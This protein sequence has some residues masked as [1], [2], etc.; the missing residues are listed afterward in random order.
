MSA[1]KILFI[2]AIDYRVEVEQRYPSLGLA[3]LVSFLRKRFDSKR[4]VFKVI[5]RGVENVLESY[6]PDIVGISSVSQ[7]F[8]LAGRYAEMAKKKDA[9]V[10]VGGVHISVLPGSLTEY[11]DIGVLDEG[12]ETIVEIVGAFLSNDHLENETLQKING[13]VYND[14]GR[15]QSTKRRTPITDLDSIPFPARDLLKIENHSYIFSSRGCPYKCTFCASTFFWDK[16]RTFSAEYVV[17]EIR[18]LVQKYNVNMISF[19]DDIFIANKKRLVRIVELLKKQDFFGK[20]KFT[21]SCRAN[22]VDDDI[23]RLLKELNVVSVAMGLESGSQKTLEYLKGKNV[24]IKDNTNAVLMLKKHGIASSAAFI[25]GSPDETEEEIKETYRFIKQTP[26]VG[27]NVFILT[28]LP[29]TPLWEDC[30]TRK[31]VS[32][33]MDWDKLNLNFENSHRDTI[34]VSKILKREELYKLYKQFRRLRLLRV[35]KNV[36]TLK[37]PYFWDIPKTFQKLAWEKYHF[38]TGKNRQGKICE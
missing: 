7:N 13:I 15:I 3:Y 6:K 32:D 18:E 37:H 9:L 25:I 36:L 28:P 27:F 26:L 33:N 23:A 14:N 17:E 31:L 34:I 16:V 4:L 19:F 21:C 38:L 12:E 1:A 8:N 10:I 5:D 24:T 30:K 11:M 2:N 29:G 22:M 20:V 35:G